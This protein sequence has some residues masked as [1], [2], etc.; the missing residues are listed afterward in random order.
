MSEI[1]FK[2]DFMNVAIEGMITLFSKN[3]I[4]YY[5]QESREIEKCVVCNIK[6]LTGDKCRISDCEHEFHA[7]CIA[8]YSDRVENCCPICKT[9]IKPKLAQ[10]K[11]IDE[12]TIRMI[13]ESKL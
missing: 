7:D 8:R 9:E 2:I 10:F 6:L 3:I 12:E 1:D 13:V 11:D 5:Y 4:W